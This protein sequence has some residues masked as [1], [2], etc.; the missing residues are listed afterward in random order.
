[1]DRN[2]LVEQ[3]RSVRAPVIPPRGD[4]ILLDWLE[5]SG[6]MIAKG[7]SYELE[8]LVDTDDPEIS[9]LVDG[10]NDADDFDLLGDDEDLSLED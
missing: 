6:R 2:P 9:G 5:A 3:P 4:T 1:M 8:D 7:G 10:D